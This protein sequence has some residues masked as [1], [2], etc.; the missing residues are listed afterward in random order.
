MCIGHIAETGTRLN[1][2]AVGDRRSGAGVA[3]IVV[4]DTH[5]ATDSSG[6]RVVHDISMR[7]AADPY[8]RDSSRRRK[9]RPQTRIGLLCS[10]NLSVVQ[11]PLYPRCDS[12]IDRFSGIPVDVSAV[13]QTNWR[14]GRPA[15]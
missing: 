9:T 1:R 10:A 2:N 11:R 6:W 4:D 7:A 13:T 12:Y 5:R 14:E 15:C 8:T 3:G